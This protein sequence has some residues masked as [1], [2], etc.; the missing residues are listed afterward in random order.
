MTDPTH[1][2]QGRRLLVVEDEAVIALMIET[3]LDSMGCV[4]VDVANSLP[5]GMAIASNEAVPLDAAVLDI[6]L[7]GEQVYPVA[8]QLRDRG[9]PFIFSTGYGR[10]SRLPRFAD[11]PTLDKPYEPEALEDLLIQVLALAR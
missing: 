2:L 1:P 4:V 3:M 7:G 6:N 11:V 10:L 5:R 8:A 9:V